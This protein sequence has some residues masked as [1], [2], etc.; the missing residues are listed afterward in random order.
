M[1][2]NYSNTICIGSSTQA[3]TEKQ[4]RLGDNT[5]DVYIGSGSFQSTS[6]TR[7]KVS[8]RDTILGLDFINK[9]RPVDYK[10]NYRS[11]YVTIS[12]DENNNLVVTESVNDGSKTRNRYHHGLLAQE[13]EQVIANTGIDFGG[14]Q[15]H[16]LS[17][18][19]DAYSIGYSE[20][21]AP[22][23]K[24]IQEISIHNQNLTIQNQDLTD[25][26]NNLTIQNQNLQNT[27]ENL[28]DTVKQLI[29]K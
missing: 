4:I 28:I 20:L 23:I 11:D 17:G 25:K 19:K 16:A 10:W 26:V 15:N 2:G 3:T 27:V 22:I 13:V 21:I 9:L 8:I 24:A 6:D 18:G 29:S 12:T 1:T 14:F 5:Y 7:D